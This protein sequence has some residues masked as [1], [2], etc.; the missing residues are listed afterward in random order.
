M[1]KVLSFRLS[2]APQKGCWI[3]DPSSTTE[4]CLQSEDE[5]TQESVSFCE[6]ITSCQ[7]GL[8]H[9]QVPT[10]YCLVFFYDC[11]T[12][13]FELLHFTKKVFSLRRPVKFRNDCCRC[14]YCI[15]NCQCVHVHTDIHAHC[16]L[17]ATLPL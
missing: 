5:E 14:Q 9:H 13:D 4:K 7:F 16:P 15:F 3:A 17:V 8:C 12:K 2:C 10:N 6:P 11:S 1:S